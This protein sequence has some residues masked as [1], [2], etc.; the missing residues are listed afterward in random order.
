[1]ATY[2]QER[3]FTPSPVFFGLVGITAAIGVVLW[4]GNDIR[5][6]GVFLFV[7][8]GW[9]VSLSLHEF[10]HAVVAY[11]AGD[12]SVADKGYLTLDVRHYADPGLSLLFPIV[13]L[14]IGGIGLPGGA[15]W[16]NHG[17]IRSP[18]MRSLVSAAGPAATA[19]CAVLCL[20]PIRAGWV[21]PATHR[22]FAVALGFLGAIQ[23][24]ALL[25][26][27]VP[28]PGLDGFGVIEPHL[29][30]EMSRSLQ[31]MR[32]YGIMVFIAA[33][34]FVPQVSD[35]FWSIT[36]ELSRWL[37]GDLAAPLRSLGWFEFRFW[38]D[39]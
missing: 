9:V 4:R 38:E 34:W 3:R 20:A 37:G 24:I 27:L 29:S 8:A 12:K 32:Q 5:G 19:I 23:V 11:H 33:L 7:L 10:G 16:I 13:I 21:D 35:A 30:E 26:N 2:V 25:F 39:L 31:P 6:F 22:E 17:A 28:V 14:L 15:V 1:M 36:D 18:K